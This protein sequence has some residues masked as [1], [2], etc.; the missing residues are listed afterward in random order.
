MI[1][2]DMIVSKYV[3][4]GSGENNLRLASKVQEEEKESEVSILSIPMK[5]TDIYVTSEEAQQ[6]RWRLEKETKVYV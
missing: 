2:N 1:W 4:S 5:R 6:I 3:I